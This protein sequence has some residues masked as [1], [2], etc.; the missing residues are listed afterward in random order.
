M[1]ARA[2]IHDP[3]IILLD[4][5]LGK[6]DA[7]TREK[8]RADFQKLWMVK[9]PTVIFV[10]HSIE[11]AVQLS[12]DTRNKVIQ[13]KSLLM[14]ASLTRLNNNPNQAL[15][16][17]FNAL[18]LVEKSHSKDLVA[19]IFLELGKSYGTLYSIDQAKQKKIVRSKKLIAR[20]NNL[21]L[22]QKYLQSARIYF[23]SNQQTALQLESLLLLSHLNI[24][25]HEPALAILQ[26]EKVLALSHNRYPLLRMRA[27]EMLALSYELTGDPNR[28]IFHFKNFHALQNK[29]KQHQFRLQQLQINEHLRLYEE[30]QNQNKLEEKNNKLQTENTF[31][32]EQIQLFKALASISFLAVIFLF[33][34]NRNLLKTERKARKKLSKLS[35]KTPELDFLVGDNISYHTVK[36]WIRFYGIID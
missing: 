36:Y 4:E 5:P 2:L 29:I 32:S 10:T 21:H 35:G 33:Y 30:T 25:N 16:Y 28:A 8:I 13:T 15:I 27:F 6:L 20:N 17:L 12:M 24:R 11:E 1:L 23:R 22:A 34:R 18:E 7:M 14:L 9:K 19:H 26:L 31:I 3:K